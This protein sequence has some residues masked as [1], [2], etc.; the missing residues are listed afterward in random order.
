MGGSS[1]QHDSGRRAP[2]LPW[3]RAW[4]SAGLALLVFGVAWWTH[5]RVWGGDGRGPE[6]G[7]EPPESAAAARLLKLAHAPGAVV[8]TGVE[9]AL[10]GRPDPRT[11][12]HA[13]WVYAGFGAACGLGLFGLL[14]LRTWIARPAEPAGAS[15]ARRRVLFDAACVTVAA[16]AAAVWVYGAGIEPWALRVRSYRVPIADLPD[17]LRGLR[18]AHVSDLHIGPGVAPAIAR[19][20]IE[21]AIDARPDLVALTGDMVDHR[22]G[23]VELLRGYLAPLLAAAPTVA[24]LGNH[25]WYAGARRV[26]AVLRE[27]GALL[28]DHKVVWYDPG[29]GGFSGVPGSGPL[30]FI[31]VGDATTGRGN[32]TRI[33]ERANAGPSGP[34]LL[35]THNPDVAEHPALRTARLDLMLAG[36]THGGQVAAPGVGP[37]F[38][39]CA[40]GRKYPGGL[41]Q[42]PACPVI[43]SRGVGTSYVPVRMG[44]PPEV[45]V[46]EL[47]RR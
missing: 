19:D 37:L 39:N 16:P 13:A 42:G 15:S 32:P 1:E 40:H 8:F 23:D 44:S 10:R 29:R 24:V 2:R 14:T 41:V 27:L 11:S 5:V 17:E 9:F 28:I 38:V 45:G 47:V 3:R 31:G 25:D 21:A 30:R 4:V 35:C 22:V 20:A 7:A 6:T 33:I 26:T 36:H 46:I 12:R 18:I 34:T 43:V